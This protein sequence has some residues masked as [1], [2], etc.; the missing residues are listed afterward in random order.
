MV[1]TSYPSSLS[2]W[3]GLFIRHLADALSRRE[4]IHLNLWA[5]TGEIHPS[6]SMVTTPKEAL[7]LSALMKSGGIAH[8]LRSRGLRALRQSV[9]LLDHLY[10]AYRR[11]SPYTDVYHINWLQNALPLPNDG[12]PL[13]ISVLGTDLQLLSIPLMKTFLRYICKDRPVSICPNAGWMVPIL[14]K[15]FGNQSEIKEI[16]FGIDPKWYAIEREEIPRETANWI[17]VSRLTHKKIGPLFEWSES[18][19]I[20]KNRRLHLFGPMQE[21]MVIPGWVHYHGPARPADLIEKWFP[22]AHGL[23]T[24][25]QHAE[26]RLQVMLEAMAAGLPI[27]AS[28]LPAHENILTHGQ[29]GWLCDTPAGFSKG[30]EQLHETTENIRIGRAARAWVHDAV[31]TWD[32]CAARYNRIYKRMIRKWALAET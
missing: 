14:N 11:L 25:S 1:S 28:R 18:E 13:I 17:V 19:F 23:L 29:T 22:N 4:D 24:L 30:I 21:K 10:H 7:W 5:P 20:G 3:R 15:H 9:E 8:L 27:I 26:G 6:A 2:D 31:G 32:D 12:K 16:A